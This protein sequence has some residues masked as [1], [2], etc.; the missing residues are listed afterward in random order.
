MQPYE[1]DFADY[2]Q[3]RG[4]TYLPFPAAVEFCYSCEWS[5]AMWEALIAGI[6]PPAQRVAELLRRN[7]H[8]KSYLPPEIAVD[9]P[10]VENPYLPP[11][12]Q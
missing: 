1:M 2:V 4:G 10:T 3:A 7:E 5:V 8:L 12:R 6:R 11:L 9:Y